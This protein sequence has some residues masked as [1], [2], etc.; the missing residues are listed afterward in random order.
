V[1]AARPAHCDAEHYARAV[2]WRITKQ[3][4]CP[5]CDDVLAEARYTR[6]PPNLVLTSPDGE[7][8]QPENVGNQ[9]RRAQERVA[10]A[11]SDVARAEAAAQAEKLEKL[12]GELVYDLRCRR[13]HVT[14]RSMP[15]VIAAMRRAG[16]AWVRL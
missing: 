13:G 6:Y 1:R 8:I 9:L 3:V 7:L 15:Q 2:P 12:L 10:T 5:G 4:T 11:A 16:G 14:I